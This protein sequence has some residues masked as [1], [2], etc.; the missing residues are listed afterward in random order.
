MMQSTETNPSEKPTRTYFAATLVILVFVAASLAAILWME[1]Q[2]VPTLENDTAWFES[3]FTRSLSIVLSEKQ[4]DI[5]HNSAVITSAVAEDAGVTITLQAVCGNGYIT[6]YKMDV[7]LP[8]GM[9]DFAYSF[10]KYR[11]KLNDNNIGFSQ[12]VG[13]QTLEDGNPNDNHFSFLFQTRLQY[14]LGCNY[15]FDNGMNRSLHLENIRLMDENG[16]RKLIE[17]QWDFEFQFRNKGKVVEL[18]QDPVMVRG[19]DFIRESYYEAEMTSFLLTEFSAYCQYETTERSQ[20]TIVEMRPVVIMKDGRTVM[21]VPNGGS[22]RDYTWSSRVPI[23]L[24]EVA[25][26]KLTDEVVLPFNPQKER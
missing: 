7:E 20:G 23:S 14:Y 2:K 4:K 6:Y 10:E 18:L 9:E 3:Q 11:L 5:I 16:Q 12:G 24:D 13:Y 21:L 15:S 22:N 26:V 8:A 17:G 1:S 25:F 19:I